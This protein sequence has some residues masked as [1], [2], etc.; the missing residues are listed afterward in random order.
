MIGGDNETGIRILPPVVAVAA[1]IIAWI[2]EYFLPTTTGFSSPI[3]LTVGIVL[4]AV[5]IALVMY[6][7]AAFRRVETDYDV[8]K[9]PRTLVTGGA[10]AHSR[11]P[12]YVGMIVACVGVG[13][14][15]D[16]LWVVPTA[17]LAAMIIHYRVIL[18]EEALL[19]QAFGEAYLRYK[20]RVRRWI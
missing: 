6:L 4:I 7:F 3:R 17:L 13:L 5:P 2:V 1:L 12:G 19:E 15:F 20:D 11:N 9:K 18:K 10:F 8:R 16:N 14:A